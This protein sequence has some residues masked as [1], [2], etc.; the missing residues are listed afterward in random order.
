MQVTSSF[1]INP[2]LSSPETTGP[3]CNVLYLQTSKPFERP[4]SID[5]DAQNDSGDPTHVSGLHLKPTFEPHLPKRLNI[6]GFKPL[7]PI[8]AS[9]ICTPTSSLSSQNQDDLF[10]SCAASGDSSTS[11]RVLFAT[12]P[13]TW[14]STPPTPPPKSIRRSNTTSTRRSPFTPVPPSASFPASMHPHASR[15]M[16]KS[17]KRCTSLPALSLHFQET[18]ATFP[19]FMGEQIVQSPSSSENPFDAT[20]SIIDGEDGPE[21]PRRRRDQPGSY[22]VKSVFHLNNTLPGSEN[23]D[24]VICDKNDESSP[25]GP[26]PAGSWSDHSIEGIWETERNKDALRKFHALKEL[27]ATEVGY[28]MDL[29]ALVTVYLR[30]LP[31]LAARSL[32]SSTTFGRAS[33]SFTSGPWIHSYT[34]LQAAALSSSAT[35]PETQNTSPSASASY[36]E[37][38]KISSRYLF[39]DAELESLTRNAEELFHLHEHFVKELHAL[40]EP[41]GFAMEMAESDHG[42]Q[43]LG[44]LDAVIRAVSTK[45]ATEASRFKAYQFFCAGHP[46]AM[47]IVRRAYQQYPL[48]LDGFESRCATMVSEMLEQGAKPPASEPRPKGSR[49]ST[50]SPPSQ[51]QNLNVEDRKRAMSLTSLD[52][53]VRSLRPRGSIVIAKDS[54]A[55]PTEPRKEKSS[56][57]IAFKD[58]MIKPIQRICKYPLLL[59]QL[60]PSKTLRTLSQ[61]APDA[62]S[63][64]DVVVE[65]AAQAMRHVAISHIAIQSALIFSRICLIS[66][67]TPSSPSVQPLTP[68]FFSSLGDCLLSGSLDVIHY[69]PYRPLGQTSS[70]KVKY[71]GAFL[72]SAVSKGRKYEPRHWFSLVD[73]RFPM[74]MTTMVTVLPCSFKLSSG[75]KH[76][77]LAAAC[78]QE[79]DAWLSSIHESLKHVPSWVNEPTPSFKFDEK[80]ELLPESDDGQSESP[81]GLATISSIPEVAHA[82]D[83]ESSEPFFAS[84]RGQRKSRRKRPGYETSLIFKQ[85]MPPPPSRRSSSTSVK[86]IFSPMASDLETV[87]IRRSSHAARIQIDQ[88]LQDVISQSC[89]TARSY[90][91]SHE[92]ELFQA[93]KTTRTGFSRSNSSISMAGMARLSKHESVRVPRRRTTDSLDSLVARA[94]PLN[95]SL[96]ANRRSANKLSISA[97]SANEYDGSMQAQELTTSPCPSPPSSQSSSSRDRVSSLRASETTQTTLPM[98]PTLAGAETSPLKPRSFVRNVRG[99][100][101]LRPVSPNSPVSVIVSHPSQNSVQPPEQHPFAYN[102]IHR[103]TKDSL[104]RRPRSV[105][106]QPDN[107]EGIFDDSEKRYPVTTTRTPTRLST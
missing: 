2:P 42:H 94:S 85:E 26:S 18:S 79:K 69:H 68:E 3:T 43:Q 98:P 105:H 44:N 19:T 55:F 59:D 81:S 53:A 101:H 33:S 88:E 6:C 75:D 38:S 78:Q 14:I 36:K 48:E 93:P 80:G 63:D 45:F 41:L 50:D 65:S 92:M 56:P 58:Y 52:G 47:D 11:L 46:E 104:R 13:P 35:L 99:L 76:F 54:V 74:W 102:V 96:S 57:R 12:S 5:P 23:Q 17:V 97:F 28:L 21:H 87:V 83:T 30:N 84:L 37:S 39:S 106:D 15:N 4:S 1:H 90:A 10:F 89:L 40:L 64:V 100:F 66:S 86:A 8:T 70:I 31:A 103:W 71:L 95:N 82:S 49:S 9:P 72:Y 24:G 91:F 34:Q 20:F 67:P 16:N 77:E 22:V 73:S 51:S 60:L 61:N 62:R 29:K 25:E 107:D 27:L 7:P 32:T